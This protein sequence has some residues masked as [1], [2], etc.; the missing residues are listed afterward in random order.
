[1]K[2][3]KH[4]FVAFF[5]NWLNVLVYSCLQRERVTVIL[6][7]TVQI[8][9][10]LYSLQLNCTYS[11]YAEAA[12]TCSAAQEENLSSWCLLKWSA[13]CCLMLQFWMEINIRRL[14]TAN[15]RYWLE[16]VAWWFYDQSDVTAITDTLCKLEEKL[17]FVVE[18][19]MC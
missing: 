3:T 9:Y 7:V 10:K 4:I 12:A 6:S 19:E 11:N 14:D 13:D 5:L 15:T 16:S 1:M 2:E 8:L 18:M 17:I